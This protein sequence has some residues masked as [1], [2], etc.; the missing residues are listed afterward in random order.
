MLHSKTAHAYLEDMLDEYLIVMSQDG[1]QEATSQLIKRWLPRFN[2]L[3]YRLSGNKTLAQDIVQDGIINIIRALP[4][5]KDPH[6]FPA[7]SY[8]I[9][10]RKTYDHFRAQNKRADTI[11]LDK[12]KGDGALCED[13]HAP[14]DSDYDL[15]R[16]LEELPKTERLMLILFYV[17]GYTGRDIAHALAVPLGTVKSRLFKARNDLKRIYTQIHTPTPDSHPRNGDTH[18]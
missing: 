1:D 5:L 13:S 3:A 16:A 7:W 6:R 15:R 18:E 17:E 14:K 2:A 11:S 12:L 4:R 10:R 8:Q 9:I